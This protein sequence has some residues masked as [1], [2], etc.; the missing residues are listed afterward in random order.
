VPAS[1]TTLQHSAP[2]PA[3]ELKPHH[4]L[5]PTP[6]ANFQ[7]PHRHRRPN[8]PRCPSC[9]RLIVPRGGRNARNQR[10]PTQMQP[11][12]FLMERTP[13][14]SRSPRTHYPNQGS[15]MRFSAVCEHL[16]HHKCGSG[17]TCKAVGAEC[18]TGWGEVSG[19][20]WCESQNGCNPIRLTQTSTSAASVLS[21][22]TRSTP[23]P[24]KHIGQKLSP[25]I[26]EAHA[27]T[28]RTN[29]VPRR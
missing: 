21:Q 15:E 19:A 22:H 2:R 5:L 29:E 26:V 1:A 16:S 18:G 25:S 17:K 20:Q 24:I 8:T 7:R 14:E 9:T 27:E 10:C 13:P 3:H 11:R 6:F 28:H 23:N 12:A 4:R